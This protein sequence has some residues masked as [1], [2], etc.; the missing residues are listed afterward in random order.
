MV[1]CC[2]VANG[3]PR[4]YDFFSSRLSHVCTQGDVGIEERNTGPASIYSM[5][6]LCLVLFRLTRQRYIR[7][8]V[9][10][11]IGVVVRRSW[12]NYPPFNN[13]RCIMLM[14]CHSASEQVRAGREGQ[15]VTTTE[16][17]PNRQQQR[18]LFFLI[19]ALD[20]ERQT[21]VGSL[22]TCH[23]AFMLEQLDR[24]TDSI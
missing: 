7:I 5:F 4:N 21:V 15:Q 20:V 12:Q 6:L 8:Y 11:P 23:A 18:H 22:Y 3:C 19:A 13:I 17:F 16:G 2:F 14:A 24:P 9:W 10:S 1:F